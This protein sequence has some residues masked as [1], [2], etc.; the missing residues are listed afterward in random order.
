MT[1]VSGDIGKCPVAFPTVMETDREPAAER[2]PRTWII[3]SNPA[4]YDVVKAFSE[5]DKTHWKQGRGICVGDTVFLYVAAPYS[6][7]MYRCEVLQTDLPFPY[8]DEHVRMDA[9]ML[10]GVRQRYPA[11]LIN[12]AV[13]ADFGVTTVRGP[14]YMPAELL[15]RIDRLKEGKVGQE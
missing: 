11:H 1:G 14:R 9:L 15:A 3:P 5:S 7:V 6:S 13:L 4:Y 8:A 10:L 2:M 12:R